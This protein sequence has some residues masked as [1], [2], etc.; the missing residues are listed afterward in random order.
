M[1][2]QSGAKENYSASIGNDYKQ[3]ILTITYR[4]SNIKNKGQRLGLVTTCKKKCWKMRLHKCCV[5]NNRI[6][7]EIISLCLHKQPFP[8]KKIQKDPDSFGS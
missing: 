7:P 3:K 8:I 5:Q 1:S 6:R 4:I 2:A